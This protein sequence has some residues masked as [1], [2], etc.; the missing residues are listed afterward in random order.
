MKKNLFYLVLLVFLCS[1]PLLAQMRI[2]GYEG[3]KNMAGE[4]HGKGKG[5]ITFD[6]KDVYL[7]DGQWV[8]GIP[9]GFGR[10]DFSDGRY[11][12]GEVENCQ[13]Q[14]FGM[15]KWPDGTY[16]ESW[17][18]QGTSVG[19]YRAYNSKDRE[20]FYGFD[21]KG[22]PAFKEDLSKVSVQE[23]VLERETPLK[24]RRVQLGRRT[25]RVVME[26]GS[27]TLF[28]RVSKDNKNEYFAEI[29]KARS[30]LTL[31]YL[32]DE[33]VIKFTNVRDGGIIKSTSTST[34]IRHN[35]PKRDKPIQEFAKYGLEFKYTFKE[36]K[37][38]EGWVPAKYGYYNAGK[39]YKVGE[40]EVKEQDYRKRLEREG[41]SID[42]KGISYVYQ[43]VN[44]ST[45][46]YKVNYTISGHGNFQYYQ[47][48]GWFRYEG[49]RNAWNHY[50][51]SSFAILKPQASFRDEVAIGSQSSDF[52]FTLH[53]VTEISTEWYNGLM[54]ALEEKNL[55]LIDKYIADSLAEEW[56]DQLKDI[57][58]K[59][60][61]KNRLD[62][63]AKYRPLVKASIA[64]KDKLR[65][66]K[67]F[68]S[69][70]IYTITNTSDKL[71]IVTYSINEQPDVKIELS[72]KK[73]IR[74]TASSK[75]VAANS[76]KVN[77][78][79]VSSE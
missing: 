17:F 2:K 56:H 69:E 38:G 62:F 58:K 34:L 70:V 47:Q 21:R 67:D 5:K 20:T 48:P 7:Y 16:F 76:L 61:D 40:V 15:M 52:L 68:D 46:M 28:Y 63:D 65:F 12:I 26:D 19:F 8:D 39:T 45:K 24:I 6:D 55:N 10:Y 44:P 79:N 14:G 64:P 30:Y 31:N 1:S 13:L 3:E 33:D 42:L 41:H 4:P 37:I 54:K 75:G 25:A 36:G 32:E 59:I 22:H 73:T 53:K 43:I 50:K 11:Y 78:K 23:F 9:H 35:V 74:D 71:L 77:I 49:L 18:E 27:E 29:S 66:D 57:R 60:I 72:P 51:F